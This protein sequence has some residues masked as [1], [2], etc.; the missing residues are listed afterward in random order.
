MSTLTMLD[1][2]MI[3]AQ[4][5]LEALNEGDIQNAEKFF[6]DR[7]EIL[8]RAYQGHDEENNEDYVFKLVAIQGYNQIIYD[9]GTALK[10]EIFT[11]LRS[12]GKKANVAKS[13]LRSSSQW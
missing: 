6:M 9:V 3:L 2:A 8:A 13:Y 1:R 11:D 10:D 7:A 12:I 4:H 5:E